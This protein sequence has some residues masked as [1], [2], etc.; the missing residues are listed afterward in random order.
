MKRILSLLITL[1]LLVSTALVVPV[2][3][4]ET[5]AVDYTE[6]VRII[7]EL[8]LL[9]AFTIDPEA[10]LTRAKVAEMAVKAM[11]LS[12]NGGVNTKF[13][14]VKADIKSSAYIDIAASMGIVS[15]FSDGRFMPNEP[16]TYN[17]FIKIVVGM[18]GYS[19]YAELGGGYPSGYIWEASRLGI[20]DSAGKNGES[21]ITVGEAC[22]ILKRAITKVDVL[23]K[24][25][26]T[27]DKTSYVEKTGKRLIHSLDIYEYTGTVTADNYTSFMGTSL[28]KETELEVD[29]FVY[30]KAEDKLIG[31]LGRT[32]TFYIKA[33]GNAQKDMIVSYESQDW[34]NQELILDENTI[35]TVENDYM[36]CEVEGK[37]DEVKYKTD[38]NLIYNGVAKID[39]TKND[40]R[41]ENSEVRLLDA[42]GDNVYETIFVNEYVNIP[43]KQTSLMQEV[44][45]LTTSNPL[46]QTLD[47]SSD[48]GVEYLITDESGK[49]IGFEKI[50]ANNILSITRSL[51]GT[52]M[53]IKVSSTTVEGTVDAIGDNTVEIGGTVY[54]L[55]YGIALN[56]EIEGPVLGQT[57]EFFLNFKGEV[58]AAKYGSMDGI[59]YGYLMKMAS[60]KTF[61]SDVSVRIFNQK[62]EFEILECAT[63]ININGE[64]KNEAD[65]MS[66]ALF[67]SGGNTLNQL[68]RYKTNEA[69][70]ISEINTAVDG[71]QYTLEQKAS[72]FAREA[73]FDEITYRGGNLNVFASRYAVTADTKIFIIP[74]NIA[75]EELFDVT[76]ETTLTGDIKY[77]K[78]KIYDQTIE[79]DV[80]AIVMKSDA[81]SYEISSSPV[82]IVTKVYEALNENGDATIKITMISNGS[83]QALETVERELTVNLHSTAVYDITK[84][85]S[86][87]KITTPASYSAKYLSAGDV[88]RCVLDNK[89]RI[90]AIH[91][92]LKA[93]GRKYGEGSSSTSS[94][95]ITMDGIYAPYTYSYGKVAN[96]GVNYVRM[97]VP[98]PNGLETWT[99]VYPYYD[100]AYY[101]EVN[102]SNGKVSQIKK[103]D[104]AYKDDL[105]VV[106]YS[107]NAKLFVVYR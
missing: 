90:V 23:E 100:K 104:I 33:S 19:V 45:Y 107:S 42:D 101:Y 68:V 87:N 55:A 5:T 21:T 70:E 43:V 32:Y 64:R 93:N 66:N 58:C 16:A 13:S 98:S 94:T 30:K 52:V 60:T 74:D 18:L 56:T 73:S 54:P 99:R 91:L 12:V 92:L 6:D 9:D 67:I 50:K 36:L 81:S 106:M 86:S 24:S 62:G 49:K 97:E 1:T 59:K 85:T 83:E 41:K 51:D 26:F 89:G 34:N 105:L 95:A 48:S 79:G 22:Y 11:G 38:G 88:I 14:D 84:D 47:F 35:L 4:E 82:A 17:Q 76:N 39:W 3:A 72:L 10:T 15:G 25:G 46:Y 20:T 78:V 37:E 29:G 63:N 69:G 65:L 61:V 2:C 80:R 8:G 31:T 53:T 28:L 102:T 77:K 75:K 96:S 40:I 27:E 71:T 44:V 103:T 57:G 7:S